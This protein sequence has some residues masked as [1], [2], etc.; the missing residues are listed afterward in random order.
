MCSSAAFNLW[1]WR[2]GFS[3]NFDLRGERSVRALVPRPSQPPRVAGH[4]SGIY[5]IVLPGSP[6]N[7]VPKR[8][9]AGASFRA[10]V[11]GRFD[12]PANKRTP[13][14]KMFHVRR[15]R[16]PDFPRSFDDSCRVIDF[17][18]FFLLFVRFVLCLWI[19]FNAT[20]E[21]SESSTRD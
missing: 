3:E 12:D 19:L 8:D 11:D 21:R 10:D 17:S 13:G 9:S 18:F 6:L 15:A 20:T 4:G 2:N 16:L 1:P 14:K 5:I 7:R